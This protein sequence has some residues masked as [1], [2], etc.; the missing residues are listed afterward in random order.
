MLNESWGCFRKWPCQP[1]SRQ[2]FGIFWLWKSS[3]WATLTGSDIYQSD[4]LMEFRCRW[5]LLKSMQRTV[6]YGLYLL[7]IHIYRTGFQECGIAS[8]LMLNLKIR[9]FPDVK[10][11]YAPLKWRMTPFCDPH[12]WLWIRTPVPYLSVHIDLHPPRR[13]SYQ[14]RR[15]FD[16]VLWYFRMIIPTIIWYIYIHMCV[17]VYI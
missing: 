1:C 12:K 4:I 8:P 9:T 3:T 7:F 11:A 10:W 6:S 17:C 16:S 2:H 14:K 5:G 13:N 15:G